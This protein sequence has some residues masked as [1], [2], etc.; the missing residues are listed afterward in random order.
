MNSQHSPVGLVLIG[1]ALL[2]AMLAG[3]GEGGNQPDSESVSQ[4]GAAAQATDA[5]DAAQGAAPQDAEPEELP[6]GA[7]DKDVEIMPDE[8]IPRFPEDS[9]GV[10]H[11]HETRALIYNIPNG[12]IPERE[13]A[14]PPRL[15]QVRIPNNLAEDDDAIF[16][17]FG[18]I[19]GSVDANLARWV[20]QMTDV[21]FSPQIRTMTY[22]DGTPLLVTELIAVGT[23]DTGL[24]SSP[25]PKENTKFLGA[26]IEGGPEGTLYFRLTGPRELVELHEARW[27]QL[28]RTIRIT[29]APAEVRNTEDRGS[30]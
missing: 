15:N 22:L 7:F 2:L 11:L 27:L 29:E 23:Y 24:P 6:E 5:P 4:S 13:L 25:G 8:Q 18:D 17:V 14:T 9:I 28:L 3:C 1:S 20:R 19:G 30:R 21:E 10:R 16:A 26:I 12:W